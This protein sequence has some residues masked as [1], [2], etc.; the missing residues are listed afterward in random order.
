MPFEKG[1]T[2]SVGRGRPRK[3]DKYKRPIAAAE[4]MIVARLPEIVAAQIQLALG[5]LVE[6]TNI[7]TGDKQEYQQAPDAKVGQY[8]IDR[9]MGKPTVR[10]EHE[11]EGGVTLRIE[12]GDSDA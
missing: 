8:L 1:N 11:H 5:V 10:E 2:A 7:V 12:Y 9:I 3:A 4:Q 6:E